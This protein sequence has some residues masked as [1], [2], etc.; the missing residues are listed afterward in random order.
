MKV[1]NNIHDESGQI[2]LIAPEAYSTAWVAMVP[3]AT[4]ISRPAWPQALHYLRS[5]QL[6]DGGW[7]EPALYFAHERLVCT[8][9]AIL[10]FSTWN[11]PGDAVHIVRGLEAIHCYVDHLAAEPEAPIG[12]E[13]LLPALLSR[14]E[15]FGLD[16]PQKLWSDGLK[17]ITAQKMA[18]IG[19]LEIDYKQPRTWWFSMEMLPDARLVEVDERILDQYGS[20]ATSTA[21][22]AAYLRVLRQHGR[23]SSHAATYIN[24][25]LHLGNGGVGFCWPVEVF[26]LVWVLD[27]FRRAGFAPTDR[28]IAPLI[29]ELARMYETAPMGLSWSQVFPVNDSD[30]TAT[31]YTV[32]RWAGL[33]PSEEPLLKFWDSDYFFTYV[34]E[35]SPSVSANVH[36]LMALRHH[37]TSYEHKQLAIRVTEWLRAQFD[38]H[39]QFYDKWHV[40]PL[41]VTSRAISALAGWDDDLAR[42]CV[43]YVLEKQG[44]TGGWGSGNLPTLEETSFAVLG[45]FA[46]WEAG[47]LADDSSLKQA[48]H[49][50]S[51][52]KVLVP[53][54]RLWI[55]K[56]LYQPV[57]VTVGTIYAAKAALARQ[58]ATGWTQSR[59][60][61][62]AAGN[63][64][65]PLFTHHQGRAGIH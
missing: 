19:K 53:N 16:L 59:T 40:S 11:D 15:P 45:L 63:S 23:D 44:S 4:D 22:T 29:K 55:G 31:G 5:H 25:V 65:V 37:L 41:Y 61:L 50:L 8:L 3:D 36:A 47:Y 18:L 43:E 54:E 21:A 6:A 30:N 56:T 49:F 2:G 35:R 33:K 28:E 12:F 7:G 52:H 42:R 58:A 64:F 26:E 51:S 27:S 24:H 32:L 38:R 17:Q 34:D 10:A 46:A 62:T 13:L 14:L 60:Y 57:G 48:R 1:R 9:A 20:I 39:N